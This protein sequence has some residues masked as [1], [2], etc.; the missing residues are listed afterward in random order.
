MKKSIKLSVFLILILVMA[1]S[2][3]GCA[4]KTPDKTTTPGKQTE[5]KKPD[6]EQKKPNEEEKKPSEEENKPNIKKKV[7]IK[8]AIKGQ[9]TFGE[10]YEKAEGTESE[11]V[12]SIEKEEGDTVKPSELLDVVKDKINETIYN[13]DDMLYKH[14]GEVISETQPIQVKA[15][16]TVIEFYVKRQIRTITL[17]TT[18]T[19][20]TFNVQ[21]A[22]EIADGNKTLK[23]RH[24]YNFVGDETP[25]L[26]D[27]EE[28]EFKGWLQGSNSFKFDN[29]NSVT[30]DVTLRPNMKNKIDIKFVIKG[31]K[32]VGDGY[33]QAEGTDAEYASNIKKKE[34]ETVKPSELL[35]VVKEK[36]NG[37]IY[38]KDD[39]LYKHDGEVIS[40]TQAIQVKAPNTVI[41]FY[42]KRQI[43][44]ITL[45]TD[46]VVNFDN[47][48]GAV[49]KDVVNKKMKF[50][51][52]YNFVGDETPMLADTEEYE[53]KGWLQGSNSFKFDNTN[54]VTAD[55]TL[56]PNMK[57][58]IDIK[59][60]IK[61]QKTVGDGY[62]Q[63]EG[64]DAEYASNIKK[65]EGETVKPSELLDVVK[66]K[67]NGTIYNKDDMLYKHDGEEINETQ[68]I[69]VKSPNTVIEFYVK[70][71]IRTITLDTTHD[72]NT[73][74]VKGAVEI[75]DGNKT[76]KFRHGYSF[77]GDETPIIAGTEEDEFNGWLNGQDIYR[78]GN[79]NS[80]TEDV[81]LTPNMR[82][83]YATVNI[84]LNGLRAEGLQYADGDILGSPDSMWTRITVRVP[85]EQFKNTAYT[86]SN[87]KANNEA[88]WYSEITQK[89]VRQTGYTGQTTI[90]EAGQ[91]YEA[92]ATYTE[93]P[94]T[95]YRGMYPQ[96]KATSS[97]I[98]GT[99]ITEEVA[100][101]EPKTG[102][103][104]FSYTIAYNKGIKY[105]L[106]DNQYYKFEPVEWEEFPPEVENNK[107]WT[108]NTLDVSIFDNGQQNS[109]IY[110]GSYIEGYLRI[111]AQK[112]QIDY[113][114]SLPKLGGNDALP[115]NTALT[116][117]NQS[118]AAEI[119]EKLKYKKVTDYAR[120]VSGNYKT[121]RNIKINIYRYSAELTWLG[122][123]HKDVNTKNYNIDYYGTLASEY[124][125]DVQG[126]RVAK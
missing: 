82:K 88:V 5:Q 55:V 69:Q 100:N 15:P 4:K 27:T 29:T 77:V 118:T 111:M 122:T 30:A 22:V 62:E 102:Y 98:E 94:E 6:E 109:N 23:F 124:T 125:Y 106:L 16:N 25:M 17:D 89:Q 64:T 81:T 65:K 56:R 41:E 97:E 76:L 59:F 126:L 9:N 33:E 92:T 86:L 73:S 38:N 10:E 40:E 99:T 3:F 14:D 50:R 44:T 43:R 12:S 39:M 108:K 101:N 66:E 121:L 103:G 85:Y 74:N 35:D 48:K 96:T 45:D 2:V 117:I 123:R 67:I 93:E 54:S 112:M 21:G 113:S 79:T 58:K 70:R 37:T 87:L 13:K 105:E 42:V 71:Q 95:I 26:A 36:I 114:L 49:E 34:G 104:K 28:Y 84:N 18:Q 52:G 72:V 91:T 90:N 51:H 32:T 61:G 120:A 31:Q 8:F 7:K 53:F 80:V 46:Q 78:F 116:Y 107:Q 57:N 115:W 24:G 20:N 19:V 47:I 68:P 110:S 75:A 60:V 83:R 119:K 1:I 63:A 11:Y